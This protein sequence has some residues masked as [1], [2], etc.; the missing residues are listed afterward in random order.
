M[1]ALIIAVFLSA[2]CIS[3]VVHAQP[4][5]LQK[6]DFFIGAWDL[7]TTSIQPDGSF[8]K[9][10]ARSE[11]SYILDGWAMQDNFLLLGQDEQ[12]IFRGTS[13]RSFNAQT[14]KFQIVWVMPGYNGITDISA[15][16][17]DGKLI[18]TGKGYDGGGEFLERFE[19]YDITD[20]SYKFRMDRS[21]DGGNTWI[22]N[23]SRLEATRIR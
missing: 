1:K 8:A 23:F 9:G 18:S 5:G 14:G 15:E 12:V 16:W 11:V 3:D 13:I 7:N 17:T 22:E 10:R 4:A 2:M 21:Y 20:D 19:Y 6:I